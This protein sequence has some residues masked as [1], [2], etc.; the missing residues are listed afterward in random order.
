MLTLGNCGS[1]QKSREIKKTQ[2][3]HPGRL[4]PFPDSELD[5]PEE[6]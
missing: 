6:D 3:T 5:A 2:F 4:S 1:I